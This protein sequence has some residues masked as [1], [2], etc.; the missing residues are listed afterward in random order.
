MAEHW[1][2]D[3]DQRQFAL[4]EDHL[5]R[6]EEGGTDLGS[7]IAG[8]ESLLLCLEAAGEDWKNEFRKKWGILEEVNAVALD[9]VE[10]RASTNVVTILKEPDNQRLIKQAIEG[11]R[12]LLADRLAS[13]A[14]E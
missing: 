13:A 12:R 1:K 14:S 4:M 5:R 2:N 8:L 6:Y 3:F 9:R 7:L 10:Q 11:I